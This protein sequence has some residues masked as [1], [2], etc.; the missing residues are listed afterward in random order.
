MLGFQKKLTLCSALGFSLGGA[1]LLVQ[2]VSARRL[3]AVCRARGLLA[4]V[5]EELARAGA[6]GPLPGCR[7]DPV[8]F[9]R[10]VC[11]C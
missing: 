6:V 1:Q 9:E 11:N 5:A 7:S 10:T 4:R 3:R 2:P 8:L